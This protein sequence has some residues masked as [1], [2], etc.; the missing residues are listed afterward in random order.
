[1][2]KKDLPITADSKELAAHLARM[3]EKATEA[4]GQSWLK[5]YNDAIDAKCGKQFGLALKGLGLED[6]A[7]HFL[8]PARMRIL[9]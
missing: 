1:M 4:A 8:G 5:L 2:A 3:A 7:K 6:E 9:T